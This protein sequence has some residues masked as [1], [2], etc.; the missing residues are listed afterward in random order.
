MNEN[1]GN[2]RN[3]FIVQYR[4]LII[5]IPKYCINKISLL[6]RP[7]YNVNCTSK[8]T[9]LILKTI[10]PRYDVNVLTTIVCLFFYIVI[11]L[12][13]EW[14]FIIFVCSLEFALMDCHF[15]SCVLIGRW[16]RDYY[17]NLGYTNSRKGC[18]LDCRLSWSYSTTRLQSHRRI[19]SFHEGKNSWKS[20]ACKRSRSFRIF[21]SNPRHNPVY[22]C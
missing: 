21:W 15:I 10:K 19:S 17:N 8:Y 2:M 12:N 5:F 20:C 14:N 3:L 4:N 1:P 7:R 6:C 18:Q 11:T 16:K 9:F 13:G 22:C